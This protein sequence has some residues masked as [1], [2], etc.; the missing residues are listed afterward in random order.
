MK[1]VLTVAIALCSMVPARADDRYQVDVHGVQGGDASGSGLYHHM[2]YVTDRMNG[3]VFAC[4]ATYRIAR[5]GPRFSHLPAEF[6]GMDCPKTTVEIGS[7]PAGAAVLF[8]TTTTPIGA[9]YKR[10]FEMM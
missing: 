8:K 3:D 9:F 10:N 4:K 5:P 1:F 6:V 2:A 7:M